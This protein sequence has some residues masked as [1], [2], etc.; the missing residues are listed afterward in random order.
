MS[1]RCHL[2][3]H[4]LLSLVDTLSAYHPLDA[5][6][7]LMVRH[8]YNTVLAPYMD[9]SNEAPVPESTQAH[10]IQHVHMALSAETLQSNPPSALTSPFNSPS[11]SLGYTAFD[12]LPYP[13]RNRPGRQARDLCISPFLQQAIYTFCRSVGVPRIVPPHGFRDIR[14]WLRQLNCV[15]FGETWDPLLAALAVVTNCSLEA[16]EAW[17]ENVVRSIIRCVVVPRPGE[18]AKLVTTNA[19]R[20]SSRPPRGN[21]LIKLLDE[22]VSRVRSDLQLLV[23]V[24]YGAD[25]MAQMERVDQVRR[26]EDNHIQFVSQSTHPSLSATSIVRDIKTPGYMIGRQLAPSSNDGIPSPPTRLPTMDELQDDDTRM[27]TEPRSGHNI[28]CQAERLPSFKE[29]EES[30]GIGARS[31]YRDSI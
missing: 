3:D 1:Y 11:S 16:M 13:F 22:H 4:P 17:K 15:N 20:Q 12:N 28:D 9:T 30:L 26:A 31:N 14:G 5:P 24:H 19:G 29:L 23:Q 10:P 25:A 21:T 27:R 6:L 18:S 8:L 7:V 2:G